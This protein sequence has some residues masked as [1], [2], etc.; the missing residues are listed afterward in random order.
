MSET[1]KPAE[2]VLGSE[3]ARDSE[4]QR[5]MLDSFPRFG[6]GTDATH[7]YHAGAWEPAVEQQITAGFRYNGL[8]GFQQ[9]FQLIQS[10]HCGQ[11]LGNRRVRLTAF[12]DGGDEF[13]ILQF[14]TVVGYGNA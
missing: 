7:G 8:F 12:F 14:N 6:V 9:L 13:T 4:L 10:F 2:P 5:R 3:L 1:E 11:N